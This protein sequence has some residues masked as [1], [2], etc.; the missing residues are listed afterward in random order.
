MRLFSC[1]ISAGTSI[2]RAINAVL[3]YRNYIGSRF[4]AVWSRDENALLIF[5]EFPYQI[6]LFS[7]AS[8]KQTPVLRHD[9]YSVLTGAF[10]QIIVGSVSQ[11]VFDRTSGESR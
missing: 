1:C 4:G 10:R 11:F 3:L 8:H 2:G 6:K 9:E 5:G 7:V